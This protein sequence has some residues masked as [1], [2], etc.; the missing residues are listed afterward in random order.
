MISTGFPQV[1]VSIDEEERITA[2]KAEVK[3]AVALSCCMAALYLCEVGWR[4]T[5]R[6]ACHAVDIGFVEIR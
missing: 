5:L 2:E 6:K 1:S 4:K 3:Y